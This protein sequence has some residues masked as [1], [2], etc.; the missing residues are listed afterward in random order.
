MTRITTPSGSSAHCVTLP[1]SILAMLVWVGL[2]SNAAAVILS[3]GPVY[4]LPGGGSCTVTGV[5]SQAGGAT[6]SCVGVN[7]A[8]HTHVYFG[9]RNDNVVVQRPTKGGFTLFNLYGFSCI[10]TI[11]TNQA[12]RFLN[13]QKIGRRRFLFEKFI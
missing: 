11:Q 8:A 7:L 1:W 12:G 13:R 9:L 4:S 2:T 6:V 10:G 3:G 5:A